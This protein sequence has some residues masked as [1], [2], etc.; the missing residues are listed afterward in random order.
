MVPDYD[1]ILSRISEAPL[2]WDANG[3]PRWCEFHPTAS[4]NTYAREVA[5]LRI[6]CQGCGRE[7]DAEINWWEQSRHWNGDRMEPLSTPARL[8]ELHY[9]DPPNVGCCPA[10]RTMNCI[11]L[12][13][14]QFWSRERVKWERCPELEIELERLEDYFGDT[15][16]K[17]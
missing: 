14:L 5:L 1:D 13:I 10:G 12:R 3:V 16:A 2:W 9:G 6:A 7:F 8:K 15:I 4:S 11:D 17:F